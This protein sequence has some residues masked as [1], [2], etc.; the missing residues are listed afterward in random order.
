MGEYNSGSEGYDAKQGMAETGRSE[1]PSARVI[2]GDEMGAIR[3]VE[4]FANSNKPR[5][6][7]R[8]GTL[9]R[10]HAVES[11]ATF[12]SEPIVAGTLAFH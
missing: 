6:Y 1:G 12:K 9:S 2:T 4:C 5:Q 11:L 10:Q 3:V 7:A 8:F